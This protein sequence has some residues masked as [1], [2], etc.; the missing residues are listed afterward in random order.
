MI[1][2]KTNDGVISIPFISERDIE[3]ISQN[4]PNLS[5]VGWSLPII[6][7]FSELRE[8][9]EYSYGDKNTDK[10][11][12][13]YYLSND[14]K[15]FHSLVKTVIAND[16]MKEWRPL[17]KECYE[18]FNS[19]QRLVII[20]SLISVIEGVLAKKLGIIR[21][22]QIRIIAP[23]KSMIEKSHPSKLHK[24]VWESLSH[25]VEILY[26]PSDFSSDKPPQMN[27]HWVLH[28]RDCSQ[29]THIESLKLFNFLGTLTSV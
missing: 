7:T 10:W 12:S 16:E 29:W 3:T 24:L 26:A 9:S 27:R 13:K 20:P 28:G 11:F 1:R 14:S 17:I 21:S 25:T 23:T 15:C 2:F 19:G 8:F 6:L 5:Q 4:I 22:K 18:S